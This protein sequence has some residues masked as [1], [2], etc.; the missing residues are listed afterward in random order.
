ML[1]KPVLQP[2]HQQET[3]QQVEE[4]KEE[5]G[6]VES[7]NRGKEDWFNRVIVISYELATHRSLL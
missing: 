5:E 7:A 4:S 1:A 2:Q 3:T 6:D